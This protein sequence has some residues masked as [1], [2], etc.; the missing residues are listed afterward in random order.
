[1]EFPSGPLQP[2]RKYMFALDARQFDQRIA[3]HTRQILA[4]PRGRERKA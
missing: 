4:K 2:A 3:A 1:M